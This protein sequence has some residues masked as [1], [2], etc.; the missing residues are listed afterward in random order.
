[1]GCPN[2]FSLSLLLRENVVAAVSGDETE[3]AERGT[4]GEMSK[5]MVAFVW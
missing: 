5:E 4:V 1:M 3:R 2:P